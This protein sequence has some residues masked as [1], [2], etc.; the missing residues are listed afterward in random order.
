MDTLLIVILVVF[1]FG[2]GGWDILVGAVAPASIYLLRESLTWNKNR[3]ERAHREALEDLVKFESLGVHF[4]ARSL[5]TLFVSG[6]DTDL[7]VA[8]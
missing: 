8:G 5:R 4:P 7:R 2:G 1:L 6:F 3:S